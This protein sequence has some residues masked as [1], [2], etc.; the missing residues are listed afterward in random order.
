MYIIH[1]LLHKIVHANGG[2]VLFV[3][4]RD[5][6]RR[7]ARRA[8]ALQL[9]HGMPDAHTQHLVVKTILNKPYWD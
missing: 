8:I 2:E 7:I 9:A 4:G 5:P 1:H 3:R 6:T